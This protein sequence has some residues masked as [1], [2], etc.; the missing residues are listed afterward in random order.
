MQLI[1]I[2]IAHTGTSG[3]REVDATQTVLKNQYYWENMDNDVEVSLKNEYSVL[4]QG[5][6][7]AY[8]DRFKTLCMRVDLIVVQY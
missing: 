6:V 7:I 8:Q 5:Q 4:E 1:L 3:H 2:V